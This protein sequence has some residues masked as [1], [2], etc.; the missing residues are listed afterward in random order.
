VQAVIH[1]ST[2][3]TVF[4]FYCVLHFRSHR[5]SDTL[6]LHLETAA[7]AH[8]CMQLHATALGSRAAAAALAHQHAAERKEAKT[9]ETAR[10]YVLFWFDNE[11]SWCL[12]G[13]LSAAE[14]TSQAE[15]RPRPRH[16]GPREVQAGGCQ[17]FF[18][19]F[20]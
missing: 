12:K 1:T 9:Q 2:Q 17:S 6:P 19:Y 20:P 11:Q 5:S 4:R 15:A 16:G 7:A 14:L 10:K 3:I 8:D 13:V 18:V